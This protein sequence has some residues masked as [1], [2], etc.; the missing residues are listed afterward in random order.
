MKLA[1]DGPCVVAGT[2][3]DKHHAAVGTDLALALELIHLLAQALARLR[4]NL[5]LLVAGD[6]DIKRI[7]LIHG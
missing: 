3:V 4:Q 7:L 6:N 5:L 2:V 1:D